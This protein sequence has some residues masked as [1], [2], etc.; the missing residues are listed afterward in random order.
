[1]P[2]KPKIAAIVTT[3]F[4]ESHADLI[5][6]KF[7][8]GFSTDT[9]RIKPQVDLVSMYIDQFHWADVGTE[10]G[11]E[12]GIEIYPS[13]RGAVTLT[14]PSTTGHW[15][16]SRDWQDG[17]LAVD[18]VLLIGEHG[19]Y[20]A[21]EHDQRLYPRRQLF[22]QVAGVMG[23]SGR[24]VPIFNDKHLSYNWSDALWMFN[25]AKE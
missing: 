7:A 24:A 3:Y 10:L 13:V 20:A 19:D 9:G 2:E 4:P 25:R 15:P 12:Y 14:R 1:M 5:V 22:E 11:R 21:N 23:S 6:S 16:T 8:R 18:G 17:E